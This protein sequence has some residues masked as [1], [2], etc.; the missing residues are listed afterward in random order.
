MLT[1]NET[2]LTEMIAALQSRMLSNYRRTALQATAFTI[3]ALTMY[4]LLVDYQNADFWIFAVVMIVFLT[5]VWIHYAL[6]SF[7]VRKGYFGDNAAEALEEIEFIQ[8]EHL[9]RREA[10]EK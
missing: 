5:I 8:T 10:I 3:A 1:P 2:N 4:A 9:R 6:T 7:R